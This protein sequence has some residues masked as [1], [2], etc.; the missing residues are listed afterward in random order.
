MGRPV[1]FEERFWSKV[2]IRGPHEC[3]PFK[4]SKDRDGYGRFWRRT[5]GS[6]FI[7][8]HRLALV[9]AAGLPTGEADLACH[10][11]DNKPCCKGFV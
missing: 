7:R 1:S 11:C 5:S 2:D 3:W 6:R 8:A 9:L 10:H 4:G